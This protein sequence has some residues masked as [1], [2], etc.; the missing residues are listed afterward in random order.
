VVDKTELVIRILKKFEP[1][2]SLIHTFVKNSSKIVKNRG[3]LLFELP[4]YDLCFE[5]SSDGDQLRSKNFI[6]FSLQRDQ[7]LLQPGPL[8]A[9]C[10]RGHRGR[11]QERRGDDRDE[12]GEVCHRGSTDSFRALG[13]RFETDS[14]SRHPV[15]QRDELRG[16][17][18]Q[19]SIG[20]PP[21]GRDESIFV[22][23]YAVSPPT[24]E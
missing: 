19:V 6:G 22:W 15:G 12:K 14:G 23:P 7:Q 18:P 5:L 1:D 24:R 10:G 4:R 8:H 20:F 3:E 2:D 13:E 16:C 9:G 21:R 11:P 17:H